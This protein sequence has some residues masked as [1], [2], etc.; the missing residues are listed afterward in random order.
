MYAKS[1]KDFLAANGP[2]RLSD[3]GSKV[4]KP[5]GFTVKLKKFLDDSG[6]FTVDA[7]QM[8]SLK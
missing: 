3:I 2:S 7:K 6:M 1:I 4:S 8:V 5:A